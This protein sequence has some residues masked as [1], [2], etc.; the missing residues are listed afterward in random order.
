MGDALLVG[1]RPLIHVGGGVHVVTYMDDPKVDDHPFGNYRRDRGV[2]GLT[3][4]KLR[5]KVRMLV[6]HHDA[7][8]SSMACLRVLRKRGLS[9]HLLIDNDGTLYQSVDL[10]HT[11]W[12]AG[13]VN[14]HAIGLDLSNAADVQ[15]A[16]RYRDRG[17]F[18]GEINGGKFTALGYSE[19]QYR[20]LIEVVR[21][22]TRFFPRRRPTPP[23]DPKGQVVNRIIGNTDEFEGV[24]GHFHVSA[25]K[26]DPGPGLDWKRV[27]NAVR[28]GGFQFPLSLATG[29]GGGDLSGAMFDRTADRFYTL[30]EGYEA[31]GWYP[32]GITG[33]W[34]SGVHL[35]AERGNRVNNGVKGEVVAARFTGYT[36]LGSPNFVLVR[37][38]LKIGGEG[39]VFY[40][41]VMHLDE[42]RLGAGTTK[43]PWLDR[44][45]ARA[46]PKRK[47]GGSL[48]LD[49][50]EIDEDESAEALR[51][52]SGPSFH[53]LLDGDVALFDPPEKVQAGEVLGY[54][55]EYGPL[56]EASGQVDVSVLA[57][58]QVI[59][60][61]K[62]RED[63]E[64]LSPD[65]D[66][67]TVCDI[68]EVLARV[69]PTWRPGSKA[70]P[71]S[72]AIGKFFNTSPERVEFRG[73]IARHVSEWWAETDWRKALARRNVW[74]WDTRNK[75]NALLKKI[76][77]FQWYTEEVAD[78]TEL[79]TDGVV[80]T[81]HPIRFLKWLTL[82]QA[83]TRMSVRSNARGL[84]DQE[85]K[86][87]R[88]QPL[89]KHE[90]GAWLQYDPEGEGDFEDFL[91]DD[92][93]GEDWK[94]QEGGEW[95]PAEGGFS[96]LFR[97][98]ED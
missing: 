9:T 86:A 56:E 21:A 70:P 97:E 54:V 26:W 5:A 93:A 1:G 87:A 73:Y 90:D 60:L 77:P 37:H 27:F 33:D 95:A 53:A 75:L 43:I 18:K 59:P 39:K 49:G 14:R 85:L 22:L 71:S 80:Y 84:T 91:L 4:G 42:V 68:A 16:G 41:L 66:A 52:K 2:R 32:L 83:G 44:A 30:N 69:D 12:H 58:E 88:A 11:T 76:A 46:G 74:A 40:T 47:G 36:D 79:P 15:Y 48:D 34:H 92:D 35:H 45:R 25:K 63:F 38:G 65:D 82:T 61:D 78:A 31:G 19:P 62:F 28:G 64:E 55:G 50:F 67:D 8:F 29:G 98:E 17:I 3:L 24:L 6:L 13:R 94:E 72:D 20:T 57:K 81:Y 7:T 89:D 23:V 10:R 96:D 51:P